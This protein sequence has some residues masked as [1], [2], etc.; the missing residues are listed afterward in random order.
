[1]RHRDNVFAIAD[2]SLQRRFLKPFQDVFGQA[3][4][5]PWK[6]SDRR[7]RVFLQMLDACVLYTAPLRDLLLSLAAAGLGAA[8]QITNTRVTS[9]RLPITTH[10]FPLMKHL[11]DYLPEDNPALI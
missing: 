5:E 8:A 6:R 1:M 9:Q 4:S 2:W 11:P 3:S 10:L 7:R